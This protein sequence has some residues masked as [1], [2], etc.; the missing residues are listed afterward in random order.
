[1]GKMTY[2]PSAKKR[3][4]GNWGVEQEWWIISIKSS[5]PSPRAMVAASFFSLWES[6]GSYL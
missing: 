2:L 1:M 6:L 4:L 3:W 5:Q